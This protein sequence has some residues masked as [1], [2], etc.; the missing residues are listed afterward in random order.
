[1]FLLERGADPNLASI[2]GVTPLYSVINVQWAPQSFYPTPSAG[3]ERT[4]YLE[5]MKALLD[6]GADP[7]ARISPRSLWYNVYASAG[8]GTAN[9]SGATAFWRAAQSSD[10]DAMMLLVAAK[11]DPYIAA[12]DGTTPLNV[13]A[14]AGWSGGF[15]TNSPV[16]WMP[17]VQYLVEVHNAD[18]NGGNNQ[19]YT[20]LH[21]AAERGD[22]EMIL[23]LVGKGGDVTAV[24]RRGQTVADVA[25]GPR[26]RIQPFAETIALITALGGRNSRKC[27][28]C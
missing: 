12:N 5:L 24:T 14:G 27:V 11:A 20:P 9:E 19:G 13:A 17:A 2:A 7:N 16:G 15:H 23:Y 8:T 25:N 6:R 26:Q 1:M 4:T 21:A 18:V 22:N 10:I 3:Q 28:S